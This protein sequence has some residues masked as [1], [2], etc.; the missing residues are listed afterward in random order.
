MAKIYAGIEGIDKPK[1]DYKDWDKQSQQ[2]DE[3]VEQIKAYAKS[4]SKS[5]E[6][7]KEVYFSVADGR[8]R[9]VVLSLSPVELVHLD[10]CDGYSFKYANRLTASD[11]R[12]EIKR[13]E[14]L[15]MIF[16]R[17]A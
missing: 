5:P 16:A 8:A 14:A 9:Y 17:K 11:V 7:G 2:E 4:H 13:S 3:Y 12:G 6:A 15:H 10:V 1:P